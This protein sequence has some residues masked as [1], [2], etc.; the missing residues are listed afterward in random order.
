AALVLAPQEQLW[1]GPGLAHLLREQGVTHLTLPPSALAAL[2]AADLPA[3]E[4]L[5]S[6]GEACPPELVARWAPGRRFLNA[7][8]PSEA[9]VCVPMAV[10]SAPDR[11]P[12]IGRPLANTECYVLDAQMDP[13]P[14][15]VP[16]ELYL[17]G[18]GLARG[19]LGRPGL[20]AEKFLPHPWR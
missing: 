18:I 13:V 10:C 17:G 7:Y 9:T 1:P 16:G 3:L 4:T 5:V 8:G 19:Y 2:P 15:D 14:I 20:T 6:A 12:P 11:R